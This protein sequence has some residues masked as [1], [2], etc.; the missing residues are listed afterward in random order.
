MA[1][2]AAACAEDT[3]STPLATV[4]GGQR[5]ASGEQPPTCANE[6]LDPGED[7]DEGW[8]NGTPES[9]CTS[10]C[11][12]LP[13]GTACND[14]QAC[15]RA[16]TCRSGQC[17]GTGDPCV[18]TECQ[19]SSSCDG[20][21]GCT[22][23]NEAEGSA[24]A[25]G[26]CQSGVCTVENTN[27]VAYWR[28][29]EASGTAL[30]DS[31]GNHRDASL[32]GTAAWTA[33]RRGGAAVFNGTDTFGTTGYTTAIPHWTVVTWVKGAAAPTASKDAGPVMKEEN[34]LI[35]W[36]HRD[37]GFRGT[38]ALRVAGVWYAASFGPLSADTWY[39]LAATYDGETLKAYKLG[40]LVSS[41]EA[42]S[43]PADNDAAHPLMI[44]RHSIQP[45]FLSGA[46]DETRIYD[47]ALT[48][49]EILALYH[50]VADSPGCGD[51]V[52]QAGEDCDQQGAN[53]ASGSCCSAACRFL[54][55]GTLC[56]AGAAACDA[57]ESCTGLTGHCPSDEPLLACRAGDGCCPS[58]CTSEADA[59][60]GVVTPPAGCTRHL[61]PQGSDSADGSSTSPWASLSH[62]CAQTTAPGEVI[63]LAA[64]QYR[65]DGGCVLALGV[66]I[67][68]AGPDSTTVFSS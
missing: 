56:R 55:A 30:G 52:V 29:D 51:G 39:Q 40:Q 59:D 7:C 11:H 67:R 35:A 31:S 63:C 10:D 33:G 50:E 12:R 6:R 32:N 15:T 36:D 38:A 3:A 65:D 28:F 17:V 49:E 20:A 14:G 44:G 57:A 41:N 13:E 1:T 61:S 21:G 24:C 4:D 34:F 42:M 25:G 18:P 47:R 9:C 48:D 2:L 64:G 37:D 26:T 16:D 62:A 54:P 19:A 22:V 60:C 53:G 5:D 23:T 66:S 45:S 68:G 27:L 43:G 8:A 46:I 58:G